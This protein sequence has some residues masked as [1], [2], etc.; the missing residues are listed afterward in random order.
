[1]EVRKV[2][3]IAGSNAITSKSMQIRKVSREKE[4][5]MVNFSCFPTWLRGYYVGKFGFRPK[6]PRIHG[7]YC[8]A[9]RKGN[10]DMG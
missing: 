6:L 3:E 7:S 1:M 2:M 5:F 4:L 10:R 8:I 9:I